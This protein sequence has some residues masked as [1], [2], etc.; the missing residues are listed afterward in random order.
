MIIPFLHSPISCILLVRIYVEHQ[1]G[2]KKQKKSFNSIFCT[3]LVASGGHEQ[4]H[5]LIRLQRPWHILVDIIGIKAGNRG[6]SRE[7]HRAKYD[8][9]T[10]LKGT[11]PQ[12]ER[13]V[14]SGTVPESLLVYAKN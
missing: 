4:Q 9:C 1:Y 3:T 10:H 14:L 12:K 6:R 13:Q 8:V 2:W 5:S 11:K 7:E